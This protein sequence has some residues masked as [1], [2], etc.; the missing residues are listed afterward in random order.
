VFADPRYA[1][2]GYTAPPPN[3]SDIQDGL[4]STVMLGEAYAWCDD[5][6]RVAMQP[7]FTNSNLTPAAINGTVPN[8]TN[9]FGL[10]YA[11]SDHTLVLNASGSASATPVGFQNPSSNGL[12]FSPQIRP[13]P[14][15]FAQCP[16]GRDCCNNLTVQSGHATL[17]VCM[18]DGSVRTVASSISL[19][20]WR[21]VLLP[22]DGPP[23]TDW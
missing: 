10:T 3:L 15:P 14:K 19:D 22:N 8:G 12:I 7:W 1:A 11:L 18:A 23:G 2:A 20:T 9:N 6:G 4:S 13:L 5:I 17:N 21:R 16:S